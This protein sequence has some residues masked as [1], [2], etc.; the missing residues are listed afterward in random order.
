[1][2]S[3]VSQ[4]PK[5]S[6]HPTA[7]VSKE[8][9][10]EEGVEVGPYSTI[11]PQVKIGKHTKIG[12]HVHIEGDTEIGERCRI[13]TGAVLGTLAQTLTTKTVRSGLSIGDDNVLREYVTVNASMKD[14]SRTLIGDR[15]MLMT[16]AHVA[17]DCVLGNDVVMANLATLGGHVAVE[18][19]AVIGGLVGVHQFVRVGR[20]AMVGACSKAAMDVPPFS[21][22]DGYPARFCGANN[23]GLKRAGFS[24]ARRLAIKKALRLIFGSRS[25]S[26]TL[27]RVRREFKDNPD[28]QTILS[29]I[30][31]S[32][33]GVLRG[34]SA[35]SQEE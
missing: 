1:M 26:T 7:L 35:L 25:F 27:P 19:G 5:R 17:H 11:G 8:A 34:S 29:F 16:N 2:S 32:K 14:G 20:L 9:W 3:V 6:I 18:D 31:K 23:V 24:P 33:R 4:S 10:L 12:G 21:L 28:V 30:E 13:F 15:N 22:V